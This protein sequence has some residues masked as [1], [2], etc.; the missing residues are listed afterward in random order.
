[1]PT[2]RYAN[3]TGLAQNGRQVANG[4]NYRDLAT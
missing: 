3:S 2:L 4:D 1:M